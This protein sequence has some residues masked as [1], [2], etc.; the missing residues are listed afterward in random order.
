MKR[1][2]L[3]GWVVAITLA[4]QAIAPA[5]AAIFDFTF[6][7]TPDAT[8]TAPIVGTGTFSFDGA[9]A[10]GIVAL[11]SLSNFAFNFDFGGSIFTNANIATPLANVL[12]QFTT[13]GSDLLVTFG[14]ATG[15]P[16]GGSLDFTNP[17]SLSFQ[18]NFGHL[19]FTAQGLGTFQGIAAVPEPMTL[20]LLAFGFAGLVAVRRRRAI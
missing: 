3:A 9:A 10:P 14:G 6:D 16:F 11:T 1:C 5:Q 13:S 18:P 12:V 8:V 20:G 7:N 17:S 4:F 15:G 2:W 19:Y